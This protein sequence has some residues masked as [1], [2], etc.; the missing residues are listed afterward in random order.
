MHFPRF[1]THAHRILPLPP[2]LLDWPE[3]RLAHSIFASSQVQYPPLSRK[4]ILS[5]FLIFLVALTG[6]TYLV[7]HRTG[8]SKGLVE[9]ALG[10]FLRDFR[11]QNARFN[12]SSGRITV[13]KFVIPNTEGDDG[14]PILEVDKVEVDVTTNPLGEMGTVQR[15]IL[16]RL[17]LSLD[18][19]QGKILDFS[20]ILQDA[21]MPEASDQVP[22]ITI[23]D[24]RLLL[25][26]AQ[27]AEVLQCS[28][29]ELLLLPTEQ[30][31]GHMELT[32]SMRSPFGHEIHV[33]GSGNLRQQNFRILLEANQ[34]PILPRQARLFS[35]A[36]ADYL[37]AAK[38]SGMAQKV[39]LWMELDSQDEE[40]KW[41]GGAS[42]EFTDLN[43]MAPDF[44][45]PI[46]GA[47]GKVFTS[48]EE[49]G[50]VKFQ[51][52]DKGADGSLSAVGV[53]SNCFAGKPLVD[54]EVKAQGILISPR[55]KRAIDAGAQVMAQ[56]IWQAFQPRAGRIDANLHLFNKT[57]G[58]ALMAAADLDLHGLAATFHGFTPKDPKAR[59][60]SFPYPAQNINGKV[61]IRPGV[62]I[63]D[64]ITAEA[65]Q[66][67]VTFSGDIQFPDN[68]V[69][70]N[71]DIICSKLPFNAQL[72]TALD[73]LLAGGGEIYDEYAP[74][75]ETD[76]SVFL[77]PDSDESGPLDFRVN[78]QP[79]MASAC[80]KDFPYRI[81]SLHGQIKI[82]DQAV[83]LDLQGSRDQAEVSLHGRFRLHPDQHLRSELWINGKDLPIDA[84]LKEASQGV[85]KTL[86]ESWDFFQP[87]GLLD[88]E[89]T[90]WKERDA[91]D[92]DYDVHLNLRQGGATMRAFQL[93]MEKLN[94]EVFVHGTGNNS[95]TDISAL[96][97]EVRNLPGDQPARILIQGTVRNQDDKVSADISTLCR[98]LRLTPQLGAALD[99]AKAF[100]ISTWNTLR[101]DGS[102]DLFARQQKAIE[103]K[104]MQQSFRVRLK[105]ISS[106][107]AILPGRATKM[108]GEVEVHDGIATFA[109]IRGLMD[110]NPIVCRSGTAQQKAGFTMLKLTAEADSIPINKKTANLMTGPLKENFL[111]HNLQ[112]TAKITQLDLEF[113]LPESGPGFSSK[114]NGQLMVENL[115]LDMGIPVQHLTGVVTISKGEVDNNGGEVQGELKDVAFATFKTQGH[116]LSGQFKIDPQQ[117]QISHLSMD[118]HGGKVESANDQDIALAY[119]FAEEGNLTA[120]LRWQGIGLSSL[121][122]SA[123]TATAQSY[124]GLLDGNLRIL[125]LRG[126]NLLDMHAQAD[127][128]VNNGR[129]G[130]VP[131]F[132]PIYSYLNP[133]FRPQFNSARL[134]LEVL[135]RKVIA[136][137]I[138]MKSPLVK[139][140]GSGQLQMDGQM[141][142]TMEIPGLFGPGADVLILPTIVDLFVSNLARFQLYGYLRDPQASPKLPWN[143]RKTSQPIGP[144]P[145]SPRPPAPRPLTP[146]P[147]AK[148]PANNR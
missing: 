45:Y 118:L 130:E 142:I 23:H 28:E 31:K 38:I 39:N 36:A 69:T 123:G 43:A 8:A 99:Q 147:M 97:G 140:T 57:P 17:T 32:G 85:S 13:D 59:R 114:F 40:T 74:E 103:D 73:T 95:R 122:H 56:E 126:G 33:K 66:T 9:R 98:N 72:R 11:L 84:A 108:N 112:G 34:V 83:S 129:L 2:R 48:I 137:D 35:S 146:R 102:I 37:E 81:H 144:I 124:Q 3:P 106:D 55:L 22:A 128:W 26:M 7:L 29:L 127:I 61:R 90:L 42:L 21:G 100:D 120:N 138:E 110:G 139:L 79:R 20:K 52:Q 24:S 30:G 89:I 86:S 60:I 109:E 135:D 1:G 46:N 91:Q 63:L 53:L 71:L 77:R 131:I 49:Q 70:P 125:S 107:A 5:L 143:S 133:E 116:N 80:Y 119:S 50:T 76:I 93:P 47:T 101:L 96:R 14:V 54:L 6:T 18:L 88:W 4:R 148:E 78:I 62:V 65:K 41:G 105:N 111:Q 67:R 132:T 25:R 44:P 51:L 82:N 15:L 145:P 58:G 104:E 12:I 141:D 136:K 92:Y 117:L 115:S 16:N 94:G 113:L 75:G 10:K 27:G 87:S 121:L 19:A 64:D 134:S 68:L